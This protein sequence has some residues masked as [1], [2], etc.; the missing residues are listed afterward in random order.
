MKYPPTKRIVKLAKK[1]NKLDEFEKLFI[2]KG[3]KKLIVII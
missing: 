1:W 3:L 2:K